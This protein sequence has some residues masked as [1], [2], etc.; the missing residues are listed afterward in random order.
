MMGRGQMMGRGWRMV[1]CGGTDGKWWLTGGRRQ[2][3][4]DDGWRMT[5]RRRG[6]IDGGWQTVLGGRRMVM[7]AGRRWWMAY[8]VV[9]SGDVWRVVGAEWREMDGT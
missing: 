9:H 4:A 5:E 1:G 7:G 8:K 2:W 6:T 3:P